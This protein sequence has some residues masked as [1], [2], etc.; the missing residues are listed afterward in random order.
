MDLLNTVL[1]GIIG[2]LITVAG[3]YIAWMLNS[4]H[5]M[6]MAVIEKRFQAHQELYAR[7]SRL[8]AT[9]GLDDTKGALKQ[10]DELTD[11]WVH[12]CLYVDDTAAQ[13][14][15]DALGELY[16][17]SGGVGASEL[18]PDEKSERLTSVLSAILRCAALPDMNQEVSIWR[19]LKPER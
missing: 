18:T 8:A 5:A 16:L 17:N 12:N 4:K 7:L 13:A 2:G 19:L 14:T 6:R 15:I 11:W 3:V 9:E 10:L 1:G